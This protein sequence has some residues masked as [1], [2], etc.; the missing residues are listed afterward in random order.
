[1]QHVGA[2][3]L[4]HRGDGAC[5]KVCHHESSRDLRLPE[6]LH[7][8]LRGPRSLRNRTDETGSRD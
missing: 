6:A 4:G 8:M 2:S 1:M 7:H 5:R 3:L